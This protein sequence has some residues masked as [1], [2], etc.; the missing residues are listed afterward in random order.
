M[1]CLLACALSPSLC[2][3]QAPVFVVT[4]AHSWIKFDVK[5]SV[6]IAGK[7][8]RWDATLTFTSPEETSGTLMINI[9]AGSVDTGSGMKNGKLKGKDF[10]DVH[11]YPEITFVSTKIVPTGPDTYEVEGNFTIR[12]VSNPEKLKLRISGK[13]TG[14]GVITG[15]M[16]FNRKNYGMNKGI[17]FIKIAD[18]VDVSFHLTG[19]RV[20]GPAVATTQ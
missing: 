15:T 11:N 5:A 4:P 3:A 12:G 2:R 20:G 13:G 9:Q 18:H 8:D 7:F 19:E 1:I 16:V 14:S 17:P 10:F 6:A